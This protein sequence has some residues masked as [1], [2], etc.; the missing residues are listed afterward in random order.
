MSKALGTISGRPAGAAG[1][2]RAT[3]LE[4]RIHPRPVVGRRTQIDRAHGGAPARGQRAVHAAV[5]RTKSLALDAGLATLGAAHDRGIDAR[6]GLGHRRHGFS[7]AGSP[8]G[9]SGAAIFGHAGQNGQLPS[10]GEPASG[11]SRRKYHPELAAV[12]AGKL[13]A[14]CTAASRSGHPRRG[15]VPE[16]VATGAGDDRRG[17]GVGFAVWGGVGR[18][19][20]RGSHGISPGAGNP[21]PSLCAGHSFHRAGVDETAPPAESAGARTPTDGLPLRRAAAVR[22]SGKW[23]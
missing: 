18:R 4:L 1:A 17:A 20:I 3:P 6:P 15:E 2:A 23:R 8:L 10:G 14:G 7:Q 21:P 16:E 22:G 5:D 11:G 9:G 19:R 12:L 13:D